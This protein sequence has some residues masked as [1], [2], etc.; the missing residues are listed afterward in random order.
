[1]D[2]MEEQPKEANQQHLSTNLVPMR[3]DICLD[4]I[5]ARSGTAVVSGEKKL[6]SHSNMD[7]GVYMQAYPKIGKHM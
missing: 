2:T 5:L 6:S 3:R 7:M 1:M 4:S